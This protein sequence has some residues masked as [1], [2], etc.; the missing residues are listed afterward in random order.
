MRSS[1]A[2]AGLAVLAVL[3]GSGNSGDQARAD[4]VTATCEDDASS[5]A[6]T[7]TRAIASSKPGDT[8]V[9]SG[10]CLI[11]GTIELL[12]NRTYKGEHR[13][14]ALNAPKAGSVLEQAPAA[15]PPR[16]WPPTA[17]STTVPVP[18][19]RSRSAI[20]RCVETAVQP[21]AESSCVPG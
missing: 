5:D 10:H 3:L 19:C 11:D 18:A 7:V 17:I 15:R 8:V 6:N 9:I 16:C 12:G 2:V 4:T 20:S 1:H 13:T 14:D 21:R